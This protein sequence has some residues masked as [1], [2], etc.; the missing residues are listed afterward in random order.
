MCS[1]STSSG[2]AAVSKTVAALESF[3]TGRAGTILF[4]GYLVAILVGAITLF[5]FSQNDD[6]Q[7][8]RI[9]A[10]AERSCRAIKG[11]GDYWR[12]VRDVEA[13]VLVDSS[14]SR[15]E[16][17]ATVKLIEALDGVIAKSR[18]LQCDGDGK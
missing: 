2:R 15:V 6:A 11:A 17:A 8:K 12:R 3:R 1:A 16:H 18:A 9:A 14:T 5:H 10:G 13:L 4:Y 7:N